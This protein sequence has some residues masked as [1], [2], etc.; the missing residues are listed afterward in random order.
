MTDKVLIQRN[1]FDV[2]DEQCAGVPTRHIALSQ[3]IRKCDELTL[4]VRDYER[5]KPQQDYY[6]AIV[7]KYRGVSVFTSRHI[8]FDVLEARQIIKFLKGARSRA[9]VLKHEIDEIEISLGIA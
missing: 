5:L 8:K 6:E 9:D 2:I 4:V 1:L 3:I 7:K